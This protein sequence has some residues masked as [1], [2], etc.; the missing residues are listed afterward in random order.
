[1]GLSILIIPNV[2]MILEM[3]LV[4]VY[5]TLS[6]SSKK[7]SSLITWSFLTL[8]SVA[9]FALI[10]F[11]I[12]E[13][14][15]LAFEDSYRL[16]SFAGAIYLIPLVMLTRQP[17]KHT[18]VIF[19]TFWIYSLI[20]F[21]VSYR[22]ACVACI[23]SRSID[24]L[25]I[26]TA[27]YIIT[28]PVL[29]KF[30]KKKMTFTIQ[31]IKEETLNS[32]LSLT[33]SVILVI[34]TMKYAMEN[35]ASELVET[36]IFMLLG[37]CFAI[38]FQLAYS[39]VEASKSVEM[40]GIKSKTDPLTRLK[41]REAMIEDASGRIRKGHHFC[42]IFIDL[43]NFKTINDNH[44]HSIGDDYLIAFS[45]SAR[46]LLDT[47][48]RFYRISGDEF[49]VLKDGSSCK[50]ACME[51]ESLRFLNDPSGIKFLGLSTGY[52]NYPEDAKNI[53]ELLGIADSRMYQNKKKKHKEVAE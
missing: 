51:F 31:N 47:K 15:Q 38:T 22:V 17:L 44:G 28:L 10:S 18:V 7:K 37:A 9:L 39:F 13:I 45:N 49:V 43:D 11:L 53:S 20:I 16:L 35:N 5:A 32:L 46:R 27:A 26:Q 36:S 12:P 29:L 19:N 40:L 14:A 6:C 48:D 41:N 50:K 30:M 3:F 23:T 8:F 52:A 34:Y 1:M 42:L 4:S 24:S 2:A 21:A 33:I 25:A